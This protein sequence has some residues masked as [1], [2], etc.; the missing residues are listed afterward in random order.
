MKPIYLCEVHLYGRK[1]KKIFGK[2][3]YYI[4]CPFVAECKLK[5]CHLIISAQELYPGEG[6]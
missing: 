4:D 3:V 5:S 2:S 1:S 6:R